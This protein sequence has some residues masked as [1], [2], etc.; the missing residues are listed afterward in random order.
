MAEQL[1]VLT[2]LRGSLY[3]LLAV[4]MSLIYGVGRIIN[5]AHTALYMLAA[6]GLYYLAMR[7][8]W[9]TFASII[10]VVVGI[11]AVGLLV[12]RYLLDRIRQHGAAVLIVTVALAMAIQELI[13]E[14]MLAFGSTTLRLAISPILSGKTQ[15]LGIDVY[16]Q[17]LLSV[18]VAAVV[19]VIVW[20]VISKT[21]LGISI[22]ATA[23][24]PEV[25]SL[26][27][28]SVSR[29]LMI[30][31]AIGT[32]LAGVAAVL[33]PPVP[34]EG[35][36][37]YM[38]LEPLMMVLVIVVLGGLGSIRGS[39]IGA[40]IVALVEALVFTLMPGH[41]YLYTVAALAVMVVMLVVRPA[42]L[43]GTLFEEERL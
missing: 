12:Y 9:P 2:I 5:L 38:W 27:G 33:V 40:F 31:M 10:V 39:I 6:F 8:D 42:G 3:A 11:A 26:M 21:K 30:T 28:I 1:I 7:L 15:I 32:A 37:H 4:G 41:T 23:N 25:A 19:I 43:F 18:G 24:D 29:T 14:A 34:G 16:N 20:L 35:V 22:R 13:R 36:I 17:Q